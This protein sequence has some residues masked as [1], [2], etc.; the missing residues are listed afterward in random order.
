MRFEGT[1]DI[2]A[3]RD[4]VWSFLTDPK[5]VTTCAPDVQS[6]DVTDASHF[7]VVERAVVVPIKGA[8]MENG[9]I[10]VHQQHGPSDVGDDCV[11]PGD[12]VMNGL[13]LVL[14][15]LR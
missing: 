12:K 7:K 11:A 3:P 1:L 5:Q 8:L 4:R 15:A 13:T 6:L 9:E 2:A 10:Y 14:N